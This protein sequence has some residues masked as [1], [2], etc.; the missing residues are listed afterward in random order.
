MVLSVLWL[1]NRFASNKSLK[2]PNIFGEAVLRPPSPLRPG[3]GNFP[4]PICRSP[5]L[6]PPLSVLALA[7]RRHRV[8][9]RHGSRGSPLGVAIV[10]ADGGARIADSNPQP[11]C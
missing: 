7:V 5:P 4:P 8:R 11:A 6:V 10:A 1:V 2:R 9:R 3:R